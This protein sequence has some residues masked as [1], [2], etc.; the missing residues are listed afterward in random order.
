MQKIVIDFENAKDNIIFQLVNTEQNREILKGMPHRDFQDLSIIYKWV[1]DISPEGMNTARVD[2]ALSARLNL[3]EEQLFV[4]A[5]ENTRKILPPRVTPIDELLREMGVKIIEEMP[6]NQTM[7]VI[8]ND[9]RMYGATSMLYEDKLHTLAQKIGTDLYILPS[10][11]HEVIAVS[12]MRNPEELAKI[13]SEINTTQ[14]PLEERLSNQVYYYDKDL[15]KLTMA[16]SQNGL[17]QADADMA[18][19]QEEE[20]GPML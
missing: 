9:Q 20:I 6:L 13:V 15:R 4:L 16:T 2:N 12:A 17:S 14:V 10:S 5:A 11:V 7:W 1:L 3:N 8:S 18:A 19:A